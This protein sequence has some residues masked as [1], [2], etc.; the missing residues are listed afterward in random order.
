MWFEMRKESLTLIER[1][2]VVHVAEAE[3]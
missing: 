3:K 2:P 1:A